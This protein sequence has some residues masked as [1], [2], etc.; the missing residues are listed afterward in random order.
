MGSALAIVDDRSFKTAQYIETAARWCR[1]RGIPVVVR[2]P[3]QL[4]QTDFGDVAAIYV[5][6]RYD[7]HLLDPV[8]VAIPA[9]LDFDNGVELPTRAL[10]EVCTKRRSAVR[11]VFSGLYEAPASD[12]QV[13]I[14]QLPLELAP[15]PYPQRDVILIET[16]SWRPAYYQYFLLAFLS[17]VDAWY[18]ALCRKAGVPL[19]FYLL[20]CT[21]SDVFRE[22]DQLFAARSSELF[23]LDAYRFTRL[24]L[25]N[26]LENLIP[27]IY[28]YEQHKSLYARAR[29]LVTDS[30]ELNDPSIFN[31]LLAEVPLLYYDRTDGGSPIHFCLRAA[32]EHIEPGLRSEFDRVEAL[33]CRSLHDF[34]DCYTAPWQERFDAE[35]F[36]RLSHKTWDL[37]WDWARFGNK[38]LV[39]DRLC[40]EGGH[41]FPCWHNF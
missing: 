3:E 34:V 39:V 23:P 36:T 4:A 1:L 7:F 40:R 9:I 21:P 38:D 33:Q 17:K 18:E 15:W 16:S 32:A 31:A 30:M 13:P 24:G 29:L 37:L 6:M 10:N 20:S 27:T 14:L 8:P 35:L 11:R 22:L 26:V 28:D 2:T 19:K 41:P 5:P 12:F 25:Q